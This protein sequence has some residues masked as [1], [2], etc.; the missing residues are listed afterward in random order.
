[1]GTTDTITLNRI[2]STAAS[3]RA[4]DLHFIVGSAPILRVDGRLVTL[5]DEPPVSPDFMDDIVAILLTDEQRQ[6]LAT[7]KEIAVAYS[8]NPQIRF[9]VSAYYQRGSLAVT[10]HFISTT[11]K[12]VAELGLP[13]AA[14]QLAKFNH[15]LVLVTGPYGSG[16]T[17]TMNAMINDI[18]QERSVN[19]VTIEQPIEH[20]FVNNKSIIEQREIGRDAAS[21]EQA[22]TTA[23]R[24]DVDVIVVSEAAGRDVIA[25]MLDAAES[26]RLVISTINTDSVLSTIEKIMNAFPADEVPKARIQLSNVLAGVISQRLLP[27]IG[28]GLVPV[29]EVMIPTPPIRAVIRDGALFQLQNVL[30]TARDSGMISMDQSLAKLVSA[31]TILLEDALAH[32]KDPAYVRAQSHSTT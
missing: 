23:S 24:E 9:K 29:A 12:R 16:R 26:S 17:T 13:E 31:G 27:K 28:G 21:V 10:L 19:I 8:F 22:L 3:W 25:G 32:A 7:N 15:G 14:N 6:T 4:S 5:D 2:L 20:L 30:Q 18:N 1:M 11:I